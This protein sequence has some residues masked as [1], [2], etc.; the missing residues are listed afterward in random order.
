[1]GYG[2][3]Q[4]VLRRIPVR[5]FSVL[6]ALLPVTAVVFGMI[7]LDQVP[8]RIEYLGIA[9]VLAGVVIQ[10]RDVLASSSESA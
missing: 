8:T 4:S 5:R 7:F 2:I 10:Q 9:L 1:I 6:L 3:E